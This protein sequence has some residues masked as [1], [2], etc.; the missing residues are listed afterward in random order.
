MPTKVQTYSQMADHTA[1]Q[2][3]AS[4]TSWTE[5]LRTAARLYKYP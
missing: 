1:T 4:H 5:F 3:T 2:I